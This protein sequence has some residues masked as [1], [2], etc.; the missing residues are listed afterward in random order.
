MKEYFLSSDSGARTPR[1]RLITW[2]A[3]T[4]ASL[5]AATA[6]A[7]YCG[8]PVVRCQPG[9][10]VKYEIIADVSENE[11]S[12][13]DVFDQSDPF[14]APVVFFT[15]ISRIRGLFIFEARQVGTNQADLFWS[16]PPNAA[17][18]LCVFD[19]RVSTNW[20]SGTAAENPFSG[21]YGDPV[22]MFSGELVVREAPD[23]ALGG[24]LPLFFARYYASGL[25]SAALVKSALG[26]NWSH[27]FDWSAI[28]LTNLD[29]TNI[30]TDHSYLIPLQQL[31]KK[32]ERRG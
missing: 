3:V 24:P 31:F 11:F 12:L 32:R 5:M 26:N 29:F 23:L 9:D 28:I 14:V 7:H 15:P 18:D 8:Y 6:H 16:F 2:L 10:I 1:L 19:V 30:R 27:N 20:S 21:Y 17:A 13:Y 25:Q 4:A 22:N